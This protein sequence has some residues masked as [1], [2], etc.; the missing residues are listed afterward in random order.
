MPPDL[1]PL[2]R[3]R[4]KDL[5]KILHR[6][7]REC[8]LCGERRGGL[9]LHHVHRHPRD[10][11]RGNLVMLCGSGTTGCH[12]RVEAAHRETRRML[13]WYILNER[14]DVLPYLAAKLGTEGSA[15]A[16]IERML[17]TVA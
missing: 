16:W 15:R 1:K 4:N 10:D 8:A 17:Y 2:K 11:V 13:G 7:W 6:D 9:S 3:V 14:D 5:L 12:G